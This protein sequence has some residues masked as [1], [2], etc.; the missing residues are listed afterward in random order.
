MEKQK[1]LLRSLKN[2]E[3]RVNQKGFSKFFG[4]EPSD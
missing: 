2:E 3:K 1:I 4:N